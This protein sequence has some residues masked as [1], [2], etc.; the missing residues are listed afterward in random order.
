ML[1]E[2]TSFEILIDGEPAR[3]ED[4]SKM[5][6]RI[7]IVRNIK[8]LGLEGQPLHIV[9]SQHFRK[10]TVCHIRERSVSAPESRH[11]KGHPVEVLFV[12]DP[13]SNGYGA[14][15]T[16]GCGGTYVIDRAFLD[17]FKSF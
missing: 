8:G 3:P 10:G 7:E 14:A 2:I 13:T 17:D 4:F 9:N 11:V 1:I 5:I 6:R 15:G 12:Y 16:G